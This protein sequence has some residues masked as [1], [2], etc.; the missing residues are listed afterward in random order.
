M[1]NYNEN[2]VLFSRY[3]TFWRIATTNHSATLSCCKKKKEIKEKAKKYTNHIVDLLCLQEAE[4][5]RYSL[6]TVVF[7]VMTLES[8]INEYAITKFSKS[9]F[10]KYLDRLDLKTKWIIIPKL[11]TG[12]QLDE[13]SKAFKLFSETLKIRNKIVHDKSKIIDTSKSFYYDWIT[14]EHAKK[15]INAVNKM[16]IELTK[17]ESDVDIEWLKSAKEDPYA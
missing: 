12:I 5:Q 6:M 4:I 7:C 2:I 16:L 15:A 1:N 8:Y 3:K 14:E 10:D 13:K 9:Y 11:K 17:I